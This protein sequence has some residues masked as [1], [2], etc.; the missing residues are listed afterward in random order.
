MGAVS[1]ECK[2]QL[3]HLANG[4]YYYACAVDGIVRPLERSPECAVCKRK[5]TAKV[6]RDIPIRITT[7]RQIFY[8]NA[9]I[10]ISS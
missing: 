8:N 4:E 9:W 2:G 6:Q 1:G 3:L 10:D 7:A 5:V